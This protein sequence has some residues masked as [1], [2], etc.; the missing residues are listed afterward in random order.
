LEMQFRDVLRTVRTIRTHGS[1]VKS[2]KVRLF[3]PQTYFKEIYMSS[4]SLYVDHQKTELTLHDG[5]LLT[6]P[7]AENTI[8]YMLT[9][10]QPIVGITLQDYPMMTNRKSICI[11]VAH[12]TNQ[13]LSHAQ[14]DVLSCHWKLGH[15]HFSWVQRLA[16]EPRNNR[17][18]ILES[19]L[20]ISTIL[21]CLFTVQAQKKVSFGTSWRKTT[22]R[23]TKSRPGILSPGIA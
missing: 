20:P 8:P 5:S 6:F 17:R 23:D 14:K 3:S 7:F 11:S 12:K 18:R 21:C 9:D 4:A 19:R 1:L 10:W 2:A 22:P 13:K 15:Y 16:S